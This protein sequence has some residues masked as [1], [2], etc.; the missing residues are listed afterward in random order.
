MKKFILKR[1]IFKKNYQK[2]KNQ[3]KN[4]KRDE[5]NFFFERRRCFMCNG[6]YEDKRGHWTSTM[7]RER[8]K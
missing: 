6:T 8:K 7:T 5:M 3:L 4:C 1:N 2:K